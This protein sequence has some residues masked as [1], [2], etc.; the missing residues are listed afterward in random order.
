MCSTRPAH[1]ASVC[2]PQCVSPD[3][4]HC[5]WRGQDL[6]HE[7]IGM[8]RRLTALGLERVFSRA[9]CAVGLLLAPS[10]RSVAFDAW[11]CPCSACRPVAVLVVG[12]QRTHAFVHI[13][14]H[15]PCVLYMLEGSCRV[16]AS[17]ILTIDQLLC[18]ALSSGHRRSLRP[19]APAFPN[20]P[21]VRRVDLLAHVA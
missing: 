15:M 10:G 2:R 8:Q 18:A 7:S 1:A 4:Q 19:A 9:V 11:L 14:V 3:E 21:A 17:T 20:R 13:H 12:R 6:Q 5:Q 16:R